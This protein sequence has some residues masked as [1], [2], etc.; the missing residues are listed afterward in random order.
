MDIWPIAKDVA[1]FLV[2]LYGAVLSTFNW[3]QAVR[4]DRRVVKVG[5]STAMP[6]YADGRL[7]PP[8]AKVEAINVGHRVVVVKT[9]TLE[10]ENGD[11]LL[12]AQADAFPGMPD[13]RLPTI[14]LGWRV[15]ALPHSIC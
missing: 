9:L 11:Q 8:F 5:V 2:A 7:G 10:L 6:G 1:L 13:T 12:P 3:R 14:P 15:R 4:N